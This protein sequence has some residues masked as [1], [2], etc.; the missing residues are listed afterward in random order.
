MRKA[1]CPENAPLEAAVQV[2]S[3]AVEVDEVR[4]SFNFVG[5][6]DLHNQRHFLYERNRID[7]IGKPTL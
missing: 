3:A 5:Q 2:D 7:C 6:T 4:L 1:I